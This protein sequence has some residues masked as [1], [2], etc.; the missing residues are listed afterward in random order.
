MENLL[1]KCIPGIDGIDC[2]PEPEIIGGAV[3]TL[4]PVLHGLLSLI[5]TIGPLLLWFR[6]F[7]HTTPN[8]SL[9]TYESTY[10]GLVEI[11]YY[12]NWFF[13]LVL[14]PVIF[15][16]PAILFPFI[17]FKIDAVN[18]VYVEVNNFA[19]YAMPILYPLIC[20]SFIFTS[21]PFW[22]KTDLERAQVAY[23]RK[24]EAEAA[25]IYV[26]VVIG[27]MWVQLGWNKELNAWYYGEE[28]N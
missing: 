15:C 27:S 16:L 26:G 17:F 18:K 6:Y 28:E 14:H 13:F 25:W 24:L 3:I 11:L 8:T 10:W 20:G 22:N 2:E 12:M 5:N 4:A 1:V 21:S 23:G 19:W 9:E 7:I